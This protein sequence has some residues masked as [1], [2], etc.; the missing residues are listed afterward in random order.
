MR[1]RDGDGGCV[2]DERRRRDSSWSAAKRMQST[3]AY[4]TPRNIQIQCDWPKPT[5]GKFILDPDFS[6]FSTFRILYIFYQFLVGFVD[7]RLLESQW[8]NLLCPNEP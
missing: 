5:F 8:V 6:R 1:W 7:E 4:L 2:V 3:A